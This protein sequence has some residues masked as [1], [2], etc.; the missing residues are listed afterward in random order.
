M[1][2]VALERHV[3]PRLRFEPFQCA[4]GEPVDLLVGLFARVQFAV[5]DERRG[6]K[7]KGFGGVRVVAMGRGV[8]EADASQ[9]RALCERERERGREREGERE[10]RTRTAVMDCRL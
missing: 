2:S 6:K 4:R 3:G 5:C 10:R 7:M 1:A 8:L 9:P